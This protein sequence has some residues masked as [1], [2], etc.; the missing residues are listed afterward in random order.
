MPSIHH[1]GSFGS[2]TCRQRTHVW[3]QSLHPLPPP[4]PMLLLAV[5][6]HIACS[7]WTIS[8]TERPN[9]VCW[10]TFGM[11]PSHFNCGAGTKAGRVCG[12]EGLGHGHDEMRAVTTPRLHY[13]D[14]CQDLPVCRECSAALPA[15]GPSP[16]LGTAL[17]HFFLRCTGFRRT[18]RR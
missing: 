11:K 5:L 18:A 1:T 15:A 13:A 14:G 16:Q 10:R 6:A 4:P 17:R 2:D 7:C 9:C 8:L 12:G 3:N